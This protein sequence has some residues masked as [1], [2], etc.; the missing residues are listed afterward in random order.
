MPPEAPQPR[1][2]VVASSLS[3]NSSASSQAAVMLWSRI[4]WMTP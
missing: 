4:D 1:L 2:I 3:A